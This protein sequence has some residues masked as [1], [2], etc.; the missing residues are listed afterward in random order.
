MRVKILGSAAGGGFP[1]WNC[2]CRNCR[3]LRDG[4]LRA[5]PRSQTQIAIDANPEY[6]LRTHW[7]LVGASPDLRTQILAEPE[8]RPFPN[9]TSSTPIYDVYLCSADVDS[10]MGLLH[11]REFQTFKIFAASS[12]RRILSEENAMFRVLARAHPPVQWFPLPL[13]SELRPE[14]D[15][16][17]DKTS[18]F[19]VIAVP[20]GGEYP[21]YIG[22]KLRRELPAQEAVVGLAIEYRGKRLF[23]AP[24]LPG[25]N[26]EWKKWAESSDLVLID[27][28]FWSDD[29]LVRLGRGKKMARAMGH[30]PLMGPGG[31]LDQYPRHAPGRKLLIHI[32]NT[33]PILDEDSA[34]H[35]AVLASGF[36]IAYDGLE[37][38]L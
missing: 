22:E 15:V 13:S 11:L 18:E 32:N 14:K 23:V 8:L 35:R 16:N 4:T 34:E 1:Q 31:L 20:L 6:A 26:P 5:R 3:G 21:D 29:E 36:E 24:T 28:S 12:I 37:L 27:G 19:K 25:R 2:A 17:P 9:T 33:N 10:L 7:S 30:L 38:S